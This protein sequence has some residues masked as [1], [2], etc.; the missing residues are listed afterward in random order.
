[1]YGA[2]FGLIFWG[3]WVLVNSPFDDF[4]AISQAMSLLD[5]AGYILA[6]DPTYCRLVSSADMS[7]C[8]PNDGLVPITSQTFPGAPNLMIEG[9]AHT[10]EKQQSDDALFMALTM[11]MHVPPRNAPAPS[12]APPPA[13]APDPTP[14]P[15]PDPVPPPDGDPITISTGLLLPD[16]MLRPDDEVT[17]TDGRL[18]LRYQSDGNLVLYHDGWTPLWHTHTD[19]TSAGFA[20]MQTDGNFVVY[21]AAGVPRW[22]SGSSLGHPGAYLV[23][24]TDGNVVIYDPDGTPLWSTGT[25]VP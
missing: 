15:D 20:A 16:Q 1:M 11:F 13:P 22:A 17:S 7:E 18:R 24:Q 4:A 5:V 12:P 14:D 8:I 23:V 21:D 9:P 3:N 25:S 6:I 2:A 19:G 10:Q